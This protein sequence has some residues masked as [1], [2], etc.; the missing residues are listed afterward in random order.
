MLVS[1]FVWFQHL[2]VVSSTWVSTGTVQPWNA[3]A[4]NSAGDKLVAGVCCSGKIYYSDDSG[5]TWESS[6]SSSGNWFRLAMSSSGQ[7]V[8][9]QINGGGMNVLFE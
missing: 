6:S 8:Y 7:Y 3:V 1:L 5:A 9:G 4:S 2:I